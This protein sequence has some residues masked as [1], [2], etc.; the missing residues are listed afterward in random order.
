MSAGYSLVQLGRDWGADIQAYIRHGLTPRTGWRGHLQRASAALMP[1][2]V[3]C[4]CYRIAHWCHC[5]GWT[6]LAGGLAS[7]N[8]VC[9]GAS[10]SPGGRLGGGLYLPH[11]AAVVIQAHAGPGLRVYAGASVCCRP[12]APLDG[13]PLRGAPALGAG[14][15]VGA[16]AVVSG[17]IRVGDGVV[18][19]FNAVVDSDVPAGASAM[20][21]PLRNYRVAPRIGGTSV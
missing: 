16:K 5:K 15:V 3:C 4:L 20:Q 11:P 9:C 12:G 6:R 21:A 8:H 1:N 19:S 2:V 17:P 10:L 18:F 13:R 7:L 14:V